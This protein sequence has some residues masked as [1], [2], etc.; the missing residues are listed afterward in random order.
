MDTA[1]LIGAIVIGIT[2]GTMSGLLGIGGGLVIVPLLVLVLAQTQH[3]AQGVSLAVI[4]PTAIAGAITHYRKGNV[5]VP[6]AVTLASGAVIGSLIGSTV[7]AVLA[8]G[9]LRRV[10]AVALILLAYRALP[11]T[12]WH[13]IRD[14][15]RGLGSAQAE[16]E[17]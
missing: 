1:L 7:A 10:F 11:P 15:V 5:D 14:R 13:D 3:I 12:L 6:L 4:V 9:T 2:A 17:P 8:D 16:V